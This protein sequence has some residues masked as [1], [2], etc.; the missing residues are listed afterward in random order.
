[1]CFGRLLSE[2]LRVADQFVPTLA[3]GDAIGND[4]FELQRLFWQRGVQSE[5]FVDEAKPEVLAFA[6]SWRDLRAKRLADGG[7]LFVHVSMGNDAI[8]QV[9]K[10]PVRKAVVYHNITPA[11]YFSGVNA[12]AEKYSEI[13]RRQL[14]DLAAHAELGIADSEYNRRELEELGYKHTAVVPII[15]DWSAFDV[16]PDPAVMRTLSEERT[17]IITV[18]QLLPHKGIHD[19]ITAF[20]RY[21]QRDRGARLYLVGSTAMSAQYIDQL[22]AEVVDLGV[23]DAVTFTGSVPIESLVRL[24]RRG[25]RCSRSTSTRD[26]RA[27]IERCAATSDRRAHY[28]VRS[29]TRSATPRAPHGQVRVRSLTRASASSV[30]A[31]CAGDIVAKG[32]PD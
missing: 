17:S 7:L 16:E 5:I 20:A 32:R 22:R 11:R 23:R 14:K 25:P 19:V 9:A 10:L 21:R 30:T 13:G 28:A 2:R 27:L 26:S 4:A 1:M 31:T 15:V 29:P 8:D 3:Y 24:P 18:G 6:R 12:A